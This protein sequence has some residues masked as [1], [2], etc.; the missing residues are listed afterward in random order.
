[1]K[2]Y[3]ENQAYFTKML[4]N[5]E[6][7]Y[8]NIKPIGMG[9]WGIFFIVIGSILVTSFNSFNE[10]HFLSLKT[11]WDGAGDTWTCGKCGVSNYNWQIGCKNGC[12]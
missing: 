8:R 12:K 1:M 6:N 11:C 5:E 3:A 7:T 10:N 9:K 4:V 2:N